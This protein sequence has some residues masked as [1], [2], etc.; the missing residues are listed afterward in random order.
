MKK[1]LNI[2]Y[3]AAFILIF[4]AALCAD[5]I[6]DLPHGFV[7]LFAIVGVAGA[8]VFIGNRIEYGTWR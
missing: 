8:L 6:A 1:L 4:G 5:G 7:I 2:I 3:G